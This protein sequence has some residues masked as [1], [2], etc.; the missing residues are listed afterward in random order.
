MKRHKKYEMVASRQAV[1]IDDVSSG[2]QGRAAHLVFAEAL[3]EPLRGRTYVG[4]ELSHWMC[5]GV[6]DWVWAT[7]AALTNLLRS[8]TRASAT[9]KDYGWAMPKFFEFLADGRPH[10]LVDKPTEL[11]PLHIVQFLGWLRRRQESKGLSS[12]TTRSVYKSVKAVLTAMMGIGAIKADPKFFFPASALPHRTSLPTNVQPYSESEQERI[13]NAL[14]SDLVDIHHSRVQLN[15]S[16]RVT[17]YYLIVAMRSGANMTPLLEM[18]RDALKP[19]LLP[20][21]RFLRLCKHRGG[22]IISRLAGPAQT[23]LENP[24]KIPGDAAAVLEKALAETAHLVAEAPASL[25]NRVWLYR[26][27]SRSQ[28]NAIKCLNNS[29][30]GLT[31][32]RFAER[33]Q[34]LDDAGRP[35]VISTKRLRQSLAKRAWRLS[36]GDPLAVAAVLGNTPRVAD[37][38][39]LR[40]D[41]HLQAE[42]ARYLR[43]EMSAQLRGGG[44]EQMIVASADDCSPTPLGRC[45]DSLHGAHAPKNGS[46]HCDQFVL[47]LSCPSFAIAGEPDDLWRLYSFQRFALEEMTR[48]EA[49]HSGTSGERLRDLYRAAIPFI[50]RFCEQAFGAERAAAARDRATQDAHPFWK[51]QSAWNVLRNNGEPRHGGPGSDSA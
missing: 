31:V 34:L 4:V 33:R 30:V 25:R 44:I 41:E 45:K 20:G 11:A 28:G 6:D 32:R 1:P 12:E 37:H 42:A 10:V 50:D 24:T 46:H 29:T 14:K 19:G 2:E 38:H 49:D 26:S 51:L 22:K 43:Q 8:G 35:L 15:G 36:E 48:L 18:E 17:T 21:T 47:C 39:Y 16:D 27:V 23:V 7:I 40:M 9:I 3:T 13:A 5:R